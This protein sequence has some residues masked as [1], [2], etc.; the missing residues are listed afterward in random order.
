M[1]LESLARSLIEQRKNVS[2]NT[3]SE[4][5]RHGSC[6]FRGSSKKAIP[7]A[8]GYNSYKLGSNGTIHSEVDALIKFSNKQKS[9]KYSRNGKISILVV[10]TNGGNSR[11]CFHCIEAMSS[12]LLGDVKNV[13]YTT[14]EGIK[15]ET[16]SS[17]KLN[18][19]QHISLSNRTRLSLDDDSTDE[20]GEE[21]ELEGKPY[22]YPR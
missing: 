7:I 1:R 2:G 5:H 12:G 10:R 18:C 22:K 8:F 9:G 19:N 11:P 6:V 4:K 17:L 15:K 16:M 3:T 21:L 20:E 14:E 13:Y